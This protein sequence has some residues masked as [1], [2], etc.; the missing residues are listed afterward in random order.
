ML[1]GYHGWK[2]S[3]LNGH[4]TTVTLVA[5]HVSQSLLLAPNTT[6][7]LPPVPKKRIMTRWGTPH[8]TEANV[9]PNSRR[10]SVL[11]ELSTYVS[12]NVQSLVV[13]VGGAG[14]GGGGGGSG[15]GGGGGSGG[16]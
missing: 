10:C 9:S 12:G 16:D 13:R 1:P 15:S 14:S 11:S 7:Q 8:T 2:E 5:L 3:G 4:T 6:Q